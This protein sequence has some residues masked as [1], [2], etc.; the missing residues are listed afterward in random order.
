MPVRLGW[1]TMQPRDPLI[2]FC[3]E[4]G[5]SSPFLPFPGAQEDRFSLPL[6]RQGERL[7]SEAGG[8]SASQG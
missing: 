7:T 3:A 4:R 5:L 1:R 6:Y 8:V 2:S